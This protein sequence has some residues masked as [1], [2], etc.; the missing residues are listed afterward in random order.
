MAHWQDVVY[1]SLHYDVAIVTAMK[2]CKRSC[3]EI[4]QDWLT[5]LGDKRDS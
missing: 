4:L 2:M 5:Q 1:N 3:C